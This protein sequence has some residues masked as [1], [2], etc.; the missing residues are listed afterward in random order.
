ML[1]VGLVY[2]LCNLAR[3]GFLARKRRGELNPFPHILVPLLGAAAF[4]PALLT[5]R[6]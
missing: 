6:A 1:V 2:I 5:A 3:I 4:V